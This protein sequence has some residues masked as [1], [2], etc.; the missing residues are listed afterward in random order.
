MD[1]SDQS[2]KLSVTDDLAVKINFAV[3]LTAPTTLNDYP[4]FILINPHAN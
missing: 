3:S 4:Y 1:C 2:I